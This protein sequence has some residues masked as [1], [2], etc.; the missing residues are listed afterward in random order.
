MTGEGISGQIDQRVKAR[1][2]AMGLSQH[3]LAE[4]LDAAFA[5]NHKD[6]TGS[7]GA[8]R[9]KQVAE[10]LD[11][12]FDL[13]FDLLPGRAAR[14][15]QPA[16]DPASAETIGSLQSLLELRLLQAFHELSDH[17]SR[18]MLVRL[19]EQIVKRQANGRGEAG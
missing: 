7:N 6:G 14:T 5:Q 18:R 9:L 11:I 3:D 10:A 4:V 13:P 8:G 19:A 2:L 1:W 17:R 12:P 16:A 15:G